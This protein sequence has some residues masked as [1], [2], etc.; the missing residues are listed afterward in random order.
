MVSAPPT[1]PLLPTARELAC[2]LLLPLQLAAVRQ[3]P[4]R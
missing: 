2:L 4:R 1:W 3:H